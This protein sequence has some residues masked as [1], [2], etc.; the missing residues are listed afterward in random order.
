[1]QDVLKL[2]QDRQ[3]DRIP[4]DPERPIAKED[5]RQVLEAGRW[6]PTAHNMQNFAIV[7]VDDKKLLEAIGDVKRPISNTFI[8]ENYQQLS[9]S[10][11]ELL[12]KK[13]G[14]LAAN[15]PPAWRTP[16]AKQAE[17]GD[18]EEISRPFA[19]CPVLLV[20][21]YDPSKR[22]PASKGDF[23]GIMSLGCVMENMW[24]MA[25][26][27]GIGFHIMSAFSADMVEKEVK[28]ILNIPQYLKIAFAAR[29]GYPLSTPPRYL[30]VRR[31]VEDFTHHNR[32]GS[33]GLD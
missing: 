24:L 10:E 28:H 19:S 15:F 27:L 17:A 29:L 26:S 8:E 32:F 7:V 11:E 4:F 31:E 9:F 33:P 30:R 22:A 3:S 23:L 5:L 18:R 13:V 16:R 21:V 20:V 6:A 2:I 14:L 25:H 12:T 1:M